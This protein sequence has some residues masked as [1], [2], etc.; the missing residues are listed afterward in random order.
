MAN[1]AFERAEYRAIKPQYNLIADCVAGESAIKSKK[2]TYLPMPN[3]EDKS[4]ENQLRY[5]AYLTRA[6]FYGVA[7]QTVEGL[8]GQIFLRDPVIE[9]PPALDFLTDDATGSGVPL[10]QLVKNACTE[11]VPKSRGGL[12]VDYPDTGDAGA[13]LA[14]V[15]KGEVRATI[16]FV[17]PLNIINWRYEKK[18]AQKL[19]TLIV[20]K[21]SYVKEDDGFETKTETQYVELRMEGGVYRKSIYREKNGAAPFASYYPKDANGKNFDHI[22]FKMLGAVTN[23]EEVDRPLLYQIC[24]VNIGHYR[25]SADYEESVFMLGQPTPVFSGLT[26]EWVNEVMK[27]VVALGARGGIMLPVGGDAKLLQV[28]PNTMAKEAMEHKEGQMLAL[29]AKLIE[30]SQTQRTATESTNDQTAENSVLAQVATNI[31]DGFVWAIK[32]CALFEVGTTEV[33]ASVKLNKE[34]DLQKLTADMRSAL[35]KEWQAGGITFTEYRQNLRR[36]G[37]ATQSDEE[38]KKELEEAQDSE[39]NRL[40]AEAGAVA[41]ATN[42]P[43]PNGPPG[44]AE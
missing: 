32:E 26:V 33:K 42:L 20:F 39:M 7:A 3:P 21:E 28:E 23:E 17:H 14:Q 35:L 5:D 34:F 37:I 27:G 30:A 12:F 19:P 24:S 8:V 10:A 36:G 38:A 41:E 4:K 6:V 11:V 25:N 9:L 31:G 22:P 1:V 15:N 43:D 16:E 2:T 40:V 44:G 29:G 13:T 18:G